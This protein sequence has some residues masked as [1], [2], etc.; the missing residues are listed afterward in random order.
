MGIWTIFAIGCG[1]FLGAVSRFL[2][3]SRISLWLDSS[4][5]FGTLVVNALGSFLLG[6]LS[7][8]LLDHMI[9]DDTIRI[10]ILVGFLGAF[11]TFSTFS[12]ETIVLMQDGDFWGA[13]I[14]SIV[15][16]L[17]C[18]TLCFLGFQLA[19]AV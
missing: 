5:P 3:A 6:F 15:S 9:L 4:F 10:G 11:T 16:L 13:S 7:R 12:Y 19:K 14:N 8:F 18:L 17:I 1:G 2:V